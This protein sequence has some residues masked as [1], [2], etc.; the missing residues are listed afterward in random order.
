MYNEPSQTVGRVCQHCKD[1][2]QGRSDKKFCNDACRSSFNNI[3]YSDYNTHVKK[4]NQRLRNNHR[5]LQNLLE[6]HEE[7]W[8]SET[9][10]M[11]AGF[12]FQFYTHVHLHPDG[13]LFKMVYD[14]CYTGLERSMYYVAKRLPEQLTVGGLEA[15][16]R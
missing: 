15:A 10:L 8:I 9:V 2:I 16:I 11:N 7:K 4:V 1:E 12:Q 6:Q 5:V 14:C 3:K 13:M